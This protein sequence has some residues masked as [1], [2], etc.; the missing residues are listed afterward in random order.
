VIPSRG[1]ALVDPG[2]RWL[3]NGLTRPK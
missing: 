3:K 2:A 1:A